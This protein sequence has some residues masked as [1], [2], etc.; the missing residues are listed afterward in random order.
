MWCIKLD[1]VKTSAYCACYNR[2]RKR[3]WPAY[4]C[5]HL[6]KQLCCTEQRLQQRAWGRARQNEI[7]CFLHC[8]L[9]PIYDIKKAVSSCYWNWV[10][11]KQMTSAPFS[12]RWTNFFWALNDPTGKR[13]FLF[14]TGSSDL[15]FPTSQQNQDPKR[16]QCSGWFTATNLPPGVALGRSLAHDF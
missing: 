4:L 13:A 6:P 3:Q 16:C 1:A 7:H 5:L 11:L 9:P 2:P 12:F 10:K 15:P 14:L 8:S